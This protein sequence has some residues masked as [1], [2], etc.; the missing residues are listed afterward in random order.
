MKKNILYLPPILLCYGFLLGAPENKT[1]PPIDELYSKQYTTKKSKKNND[2][3]L[4]TFHYDD[5]ELVDVINDLASQKGVNVEMPM[6][7]NAITSKITFHMDYQISLDEAWEMLYTILDVAGYSLIPK[8]SMYNIVKTSPA[9]SKEVIPLYVGMEPKD[10]PDFDQ[11]I[12]YLYYLTNIK[13]SNDPNPANNELSGILKELLPDTASYQFDPKVNAVLVTDKANNIK[14]VMEIVA[15]LDET[16]FQEKLDIV[17]LRYTPAQF[18]A[19]LF[20]K[21][22]LKTT[23]PDAAKYRAQGK[24]SD[25]SSYFSDQ[26]KLIPEPRSNKLIIFGKPQA[27]SRVKEFIYKYIDVEMESGNSILHVYQLLYLDAATFATVLTN[28]VKSELPGGTG[29][30]SAGA[31]KTGVER[32]F[33]GVIIKADVPVVTGASASLFG[34]NKL[35][36]AAK[37]DDWKHIKRI[38]E[39][40]DKPQSQVII[41]VLIADLTIDDIN[42]L[43]AQVRNPM[44]LPMPGEVNAQSAQIAPVIP[45]SFSNPTTIAS[46]LLGNVIPQASGPPVSIASLATLNSSNLIQISDPTTGKSWGVA[47]LLQLLSSTKIISHPHLIITNNQLGSV[48]IGEQRLLPGETTA[49]AA[50]PTIKQDTVPA[51]LKV[52]IKPRISSSNNVNLQVS[53][54]IT[55]FV[56]GS[57]T[58]ITRQIITNAYVQS[59]DILALGGLIRDDL[60]DTMS[61]TPWIGQIPILGWLFKKRRTEIVK[62][63]LTVFICPTI[64]E[65]QL[66][67]GINNYTKDYIKLNEKYINEAQLF[68]T[69]RDPITRFFFRTNVDINDE[70]NEF[71][72]KDEL[73]RDPSLVLLTPEQEQKVEEAAERQTLQKGT[74]RRNQIIAAAK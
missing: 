55:E 6:G 2:E 30:S 36:I 15:S 62:T 71:I 48:T 63:N 47:Q 34:S 25:G 5:E 4:I 17:W 18:V 69:L 26:V 56:A 68:D 70:V 24:K 46:D 23:G 12:R 40:L 64:I 8:G 49:T 10:L 29:Q 43:G 22:I 59:G 72:S 19:D 38:I 41:E 27:V 53:I 20:N 1:Q 66:R 31:A 74:R 54:D 50:A 28:I 21:D 52:S 13:V 37:N 42:Q 45:D 60:A 11:R 3:H 58:R 35:I 7:A 33:E 14:S 16:T 67:G 32:Y 57:N 73:K 65:P 9:V 51:N 39:Q 44:A 61:E